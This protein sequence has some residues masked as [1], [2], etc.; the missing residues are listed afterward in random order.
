VDYSLCFK[1]AAFNRLPV[2]IAAEVISHLVQAMV[3]NNVGYLKAHQAPLLYETGVRYRRDEQ[4]TEMQWWDIPSILRAGY[5]D[6][7]GLAAWR[8]AELRH[9]GYS[10]TPRVVTDNGKVFHV[11]VLGPRGIE[12]PSEILGMP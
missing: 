2:P 1:L 8:V 11:Q 10:A 5:A 12:D 7:K 3:A 6:C 9:A 4:G